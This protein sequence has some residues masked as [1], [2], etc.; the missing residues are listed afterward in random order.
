MINCMARSKNHMYMYLFSILQ[1]TNMEK[2]LDLH[3]P[4]YTWTYLDIPGPASTW[5]YLDL[6]IHIHT[7]TC[8]QRLDF[9]H[10]YMQT[11]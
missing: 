11:M 4:G 3:L 5:T 6:D 2:L 10:F 1:L 8:H 9:V 7:R